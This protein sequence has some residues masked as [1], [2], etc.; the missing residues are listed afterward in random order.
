MADFDLIS[1]F[2]DAGLADKG[3]L[4]EWQN[5]GGLQMRFRLTKDQKWLANEVC[6]GGCWHLWDIPE[7]WQLEG[8][9]LR[10]MTEYCDER[11]VEVR[12]GM[13]GFYVVREGMVLTDG[14]WRLDTPGVITNEWSV[15]FFPTRP[16]ALLAAC[17]AIASEETAD[18]Q[19]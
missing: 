2:I 13:P 15:L 10:Q 12:K 3:V 17:V 8:Q 11:G 14:G 9:L 7:S 18:G 19:A 1:A 16:E 5:D 6:D 4:R